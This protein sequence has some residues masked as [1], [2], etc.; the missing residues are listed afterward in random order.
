M[1]DPVYVYIVRSRFSTADGRSYAVGQKVTAGE[2]AA[3][4]PQFDAYAV[5]REAGEHDPADALVEAPAAPA[6]FV[7]KVADP[8]KPSDAPA[9]P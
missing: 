1:N 2:A 3:N 4:Q 9:V 7:A 8:P 6:P 5:K